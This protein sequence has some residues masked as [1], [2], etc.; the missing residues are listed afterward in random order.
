MMAVSSMSSSSCFT[1]SASI[2]HPSLL[3]H[4]NLIHKSSFSLNGKRLG[5]GLQNNFNFCLKLNHRGHFSYLGKKFGPTRNCS[6]IMVRKVYFNFSN[7]NDQGIRIK[8]LFDKVWHVLCYNG[9]VKHGCQLGKRSMM[10]ATDLVAAGFTGITDIAGGYAVW[11][12]TGLP[13]EI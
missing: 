1:S 8:M 2:R 9:I 4:K 5:T 13:T 6:D 12:Q 3:S 11:T 7:S 10:A